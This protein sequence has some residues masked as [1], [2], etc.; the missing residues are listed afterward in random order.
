MNS[1]EPFETAEEFF[2]GT[3]R[4]FLECIKGAIAERGTCSVALSG[5]ETPKQFFR[6]LLDNPEIDSISWERVFFFWVD[7]RCVPADSIYSNYGLAKELL[8][9]SLPIP[10][11]NIFPMNGE[12]SPEDSA[13]SYQKDMKKH[14][15]SVKS[16]EFP[17]FDFMLM[18]MGPDGHIASLFPNR[19]ELDEKNA[20][21]ISA[22]PPVTAKPEVPRVSITLPV[23]NSSANTLFLIKGKE[24]QSIVRDF[25]DNQQAVYNLPVTLIKPTG[26]LKWFFM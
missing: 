14:F 3:V 4:Y 12:L 16:D 24:K 26:K 2:N 10:V 22:E 21:V 6:T 20:W 13:A 5:G 8:L 25:L 15:S 18:G 17:V 23:I 11:E 1:I 7:D 19:E 9:D